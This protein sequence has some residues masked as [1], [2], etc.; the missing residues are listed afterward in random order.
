MEEI[1][2]IEV[3]VDE[4]MKLLD[5]CSNG[6][7][8]VEKLLLNDASININ[9]L[10]VIACKEGFVEIVKLLLNDGRVDVNKLDV[11]GETPFYFDFECNDKRTE[12]VKLLGNR[13]FSGQTPLWV[14]CRKGHIEIVKL[15]LKDKRV[16][17]NKVNKHG[18]TP[19]WIACSKGQIEV[20]KLMLND[21]RTDVRKAQVNDKT[22]F[23]GACQNSNLEIVEHMLA[24]G[25]DVNLAQESKNEKKTALCCAWRERNS[26][27]RE[28]ENGKDFKKRLKNSQK[29]INLINEF[30]RKPNQTRIKLRKQLRILGKFFSSQ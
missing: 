2:E 8:E 17:I 25:R 11:L 19:F 26:E 30:Q 3:E 14:A 5:A 4:V 15:L 20:V 18:E 6:R 12:I 13:N 7:F 28:W 23:F 21:Q 10:F 1:E 22:P 9:R 27:Q 16:D 29:I 24:S